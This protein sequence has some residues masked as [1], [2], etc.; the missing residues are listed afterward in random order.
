[1]RQRGWG[2]TREHAVWDSRGWDNRTAVRRLQGKHSWR[3]KQDPIWGQD[4]ESRELSAYR[5]HPQHNQPAIPHIP[6][7][8][9]K[10][11]VYEKKQNINSNLTG[12]CYV[13]A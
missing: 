3:V 5:Q 9:G 1:M 10:T 7:N 13:S 8:S 2:N 4:R 12:K 6:H 11:Q